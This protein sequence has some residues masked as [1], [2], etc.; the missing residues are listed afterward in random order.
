MPRDVPLELLGPLACGVQTG[1]P[2]VL[3]VLRPE[4]GATLAVSGAGGVGLSALIAA[5]HL[6]GATTTVVDVNCRPVGLTGGCRDARRLRGS[7]A[8]LDRC[9][10]PGSD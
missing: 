5:A 7:T 8:R 10:T 6:T 4:P 3:D 9:V 2:F 1:A